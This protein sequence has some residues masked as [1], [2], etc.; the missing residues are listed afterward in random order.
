VKAHPEI[1]QHILKGR[2]EKGLEGWLDAYTDGLDSRC[3]EVKSKSFKNDEGEVTLRITM[4][5]F[6][7]E[8]HDYMHED[9]DGGVWWPIEEKTLS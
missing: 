3:L 8:G 4:V 7:E 1:V 2:P 6:Q 5:C 9:V